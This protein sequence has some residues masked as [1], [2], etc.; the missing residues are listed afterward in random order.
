MRKKYS[1]II[2]LMA[3]IALGCSSLTACKKQEESETDS[4]LQ[5]ESTVIQTD[6]L[7]NSDNSSHAEKLVETVPEETEE[8]TTEH[9][10]PTETITVQSGTQLEISD[11]TL[12][13]ETNKNYPISLKDLIQQGDSV[14]SF[15]FEF[16]ADANIGTYQG[17]CGISVN[18][19]C[20]AATNDHWYQSAD[21]NVV[22]EGKYVKITWD[23]PE[24]IQ[25]DIDA[26]GKIQIGYWWGDTMEVNLKYVTCNYTRTSTIPV[27]DTVEIPVGQQLNYHSDTEKSTRI[28]LADILDDNYT[29]QTITFDISSE[30]AFGKFTGAFGIQITDDWYQSETIVKFSDENHLSLTWLIPEDIKYSIPK[31][32]ET[33]FNYWWGET[34]NIILDSITVKYSYGSQGMLDKNRLPDGVDIQVMHQ[35]EDAKKIVENMTVGWNLGNTLDCYNVTWSV[36]EF[37]TAWG[38]P[39]TTKKM[40]DTVKF[41]GFN[42]VRIP[43]SWTDH[44]DEEGNIDSIWLNRVQQVVDYA[45]DNNLYTIINMHHDDYTWLN[46]TYADEEEITKKYI[47]I[48][49]QI[50]ERFQNYDTKLLFEGLNEPRVVGSDEEWTGGTPEEHEVINHLLQEF[51]NTVRKS[52]GNNSMRTLIITTHAASIEETAINGLQLPND[53]NFI[54]SIHNYSPWKFT[55]Y[56][57]QN[58]NKFDESAKKE[59]SAQFDYLYETFVSKNI[60]VIIGEFGAENKNNTKARAEYYNYYISEADKHGIPCIIWDNNV[61]DGEGSYGLFDRETCDWHYEEIITA[62]Q[63]AI[64]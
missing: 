30:S 36:S 46:P 24:E 41:A 22:S 12:N 51:I 34:D 20:E 45:M 29:P 50:A 23:V 25:N 19:D 60:P 27:D 9:I 16:E 14:Q 53:D 17:G 38:N 61:F 57:Y 6:N 32:A 56:E 7:V 55:T 64:N 40:I 48:W 3:T 42:T 11:V 5:L 28:S 10:S 31:N 4:Q 35:N 1:R 44:I 43:V 63:N 54:I 59:L 13:H 8:P 33:E 2:A 26:N 52:G 18:E 47:K 15:I 58:N 37:E 21:F 49:E 39:K 62:I